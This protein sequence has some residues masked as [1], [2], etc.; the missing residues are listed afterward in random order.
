MESKGESESKVFVGAADGRPDFSQLPVLLHVLLGEKELN[1]AE[2]NALI[3]GSIIELETREGEPVDLAV[4][5]KRIG[6]GELVNVDGK[7]G[8]KI[9]NW[10]SN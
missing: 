10:R 1:L 6:K 3:P 4:N 2:A 5:G 7:L 9:L 8:V